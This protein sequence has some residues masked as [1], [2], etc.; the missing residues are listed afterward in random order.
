[1]PCPLLS[2]QHRWWGPFVSGSAN[3]RAHP[4]GHHLHGLRKS[5]EL[6]SIVGKNPT[7]WRH[8]GVVRPSPPPRLPLPRPCPASHRASPSPISL[9]LASCERLALRTFSLLL[10]QFQHTL[11]RCA[12]LLSP[13]GRPRLWPLTLR[14]LAMAVRQRH[15]FARDSLMFFRHQLRLV[16]P[17]TSGGALTSD[18]WCCE[19]T[20]TVLPIDGWRCIHRLWR[21]FHQSRQ[22]LP[23]A[24]GGASEATTMLPWA[25]TMLPSMG[26]DYMRTAAVLRVLGAA[27]VA[28]NF[29]L[30]KFCYFAKIVYRCC[31]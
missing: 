22:L 26:V 1:M 2:C 27:T 29:L 18:S 15:R 7:S 8:P 9:R 31:Y 20:S 28:R 21:C 11:P 23:A 12:L 4:R 14:G 5:G 25:T 19:P 13:R 17:T 30:Q 24:S 16:L 10:G 6:T 3:S